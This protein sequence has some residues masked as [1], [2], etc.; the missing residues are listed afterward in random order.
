MNLK[1][2]LI[3]FL[4]F[5]SCSS[6]KPK[7]FSFDDIMTAKM[8]GIISN[9]RFTANDG[10]SIAY[11]KYISKKEKANL[12][13]VH[14]GGAHSGA[15]YQKLAYELSN[16]YGI[17]TYLIDF[18]GHGKSEG[19]RGDSSSVEIVYSDIEQMIQIVRGYSDNPLFLGG[20]SSGSGLIL[21]LFDGKSNLP[22]SGLLFLSP[23]F[24]F[25]SKTSRENI[26]IPFANP[27]INIFVLSEL[28]G[29]KLFG[30]TTAVTFN[31]P[32][33]IL[34]MDP[35]L[36]NSIS[37]NMAN[38]LTPND[39][40]NQ[41]SQ[42]SIPL[43]IWIGANDELIDPDKLKSF[44]ENSFQS[45]NSESLFTV[46]PNENHLSILIEASKPMSQFIYKRIQF[47]QNKK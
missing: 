3:G 44:T 26:K 29:K 1:F 39:P 35:L 12:I 40:S 23:E 14:G 16:Q 17:S 43:G 19:D 46:I 22:L 33:E 45:N 30:N 6:S 42:I 21:N 27:R 2:L 41:L 18:R 32:A 31:Y 25:R 5:Y 24:G 38:A 34:Q 10:T 47:I 7:S 15:G 20:H 13:F 37:T 8:P 36:I 9:D 11:Y 28:T 4:F